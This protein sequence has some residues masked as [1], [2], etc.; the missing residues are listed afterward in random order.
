[1]AGSEVTVV[2]KARDEASKKL[3]GI[4]KAS[5]GLTAGFA[6]VGA[7]SIKAAADFEH[8]LSQVKAVSGATE[9]EMKGLRAEALAIGKDTKFGAG[10]AT[11]A[12]H[13]LAAG[14]I[15][16]KDILG[17]A[18][19]AAADLAAA[20]GTDL[21]QAAN[22]IATSMSVWK[23]E[24]TQTTDVVNRLAGAANVS[25]FG[26]EDMAL[27]IAQGGG[28]AASAGVDFADFSTTI[29]ATAS[30][31]SSG[32]DAGT[33]FKTF[34]IALA[35]PTGKAKEAME[36]LGLAF[37]DAQGQ[38]KPM[39]EI[40]QE[41]HDKLGP[42]SEQQ[43]AQAAATIFGNDAM[44][45]AVGLA[46]LTGA[47]FEAMSASMGSTS[48]ADVARTRM[49]NLSGSLEELKGSLETAAIQL[50]SKFL[51]VLNDGVQGATDVVNAF[52]ELPGSTQNIVL[53]GGAAVTA[54]PAV[55][56]L[57]EKA[58]ATGQKLLAMGEAS[59]KAKLAIGGAGVLGAVVGLDLALQGLTGKGLVATVKGFVE[60]ATES[61][62]FGKA[63]QKVRLEIEK[64]EGLTGGD[65]FAVLA[66]DL[67]K[68]ADAFDAATI[69]NLSKWGG[70]Y[71]DLNATSLELTRSLPQMSSALDESI[72]RL[73]EL[74]DNGHKTGREMKAALEE[75]QA[76]AFGFGAGM[77]QLGT[78][79]GDLY[80]EMAKLPEPMQAAFAEGAGLTAQQEALQRA[81]EATNTTIDVGIED[82]KALARA[83]NETAIA[84]EALAK[85]S[86]QEWVEEVTGGF[87]EADDKAKALTDTIDAMVGRF[88]S[89]NPVAEAARAAHAALSEELGDLKAKGD[90]VTTAEAARIAQIE[91]KLLPALEKE[92][93]AFNENETAM[94]GQRAALTQ[95]MG[96][97]GYGKLLSVLGDAKVA[98]EDQLYV[99]GQAS[100]AYYSLTHD[101]IP[102]AVQQ[103]SKLKSELSPEV[104]KPIAEAIGPALVEAI[105]NGVADPQKRAELLAIVD[106]LIGSAI[107][108]GEAK[109]ANAATIGTR[110][111]EGLASGLR[112]SGAVV[113]AAAQ[114]IIQAALTA[115]QTEAVIR[116][117]SKLFHDDVG[118]PLGEGIAAGVA[119][120]EGVVTAAAVGV[121]AKAA[122]AAKTYTD[123]MPFAEIPGTMPSAGKVGG[124]YYT[125]GGTAGTSYTWEGLD[126]GSVVKDVASGKVAA[127]MFDPE[128]RARIEDQFRVV[129][130][131]ASWSAP[132]PF[133]PGQSYAD[134]VASP[135][136]LP[137]GYRWDKAPGGGMVVVQISGPGMAQLA[138]D[139]TVTSGA[140]FA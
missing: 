136:P 46:Q 44:R 81:M 114:A 103:F 68:A 17:G 121:V 60:G 45:T 52:G 110:L 33:S 42:L 97:G 36:E 116:S 2:I 16:A 49:D 79:T 99:I 77:A 50:G 109:A 135:G 82:I 76:A 101:D 108:S 140:V 86:I 37:Y 47:E 71:K 72:I 22:T 23:L 80:R 120:T 129:G 34:L 20:G 119:A 67:Q 55:I 98:H 9:A 41:L 78:T 57:G 126:Y 31:F 35:N 73:A 4:T 7:A 128:T 106:E 13:E 28:V 39:S 64:L 89:L 19:R 11:K 48:A 90:A 122:A 118:V 18:A 54:L 3:D 30:S 26:V 130:L 53:F 139:I 96:E 14:G 107:T 115:A 104:W 111:A 93:T 91:G 24:T 117:P 88:D 70:E 131:P 58:I 40:V 43:R 85:T 10:E 5:L 95:L 38:L 113:D 61:E 133:T 83:H 138:S 66:S 84:T 94:K 124:P 6:A 132:A 127:W 65:Q 56:G 102:A 137:D 8:G 87:E 59:A 1:M 125:T 92:L 32:S 27:A 15:E 21:A 75:A 62:R 29:A 63:V 123:T 25:R 12:M 105:K 100:K 51:P 112:S 74:G 134:A 69:Q